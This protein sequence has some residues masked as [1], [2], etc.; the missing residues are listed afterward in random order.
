VSVSPCASWRVFTEEYHAK[1]HCD[2]EDEGDYEG[3]APGL[4]RGQATVVNQG[5]ED[6]GHDEAGCSD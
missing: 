1:S 2:N 4:V 5:V 3:Y 6:C